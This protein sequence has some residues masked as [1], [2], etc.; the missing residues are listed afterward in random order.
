MNEVQMMS[1]STGVSDLLLH[2]ARNSHRKSPRSNGSRV[3]YTCRLRGGE[4]VVG[5]CGE[6]AR[7]VRAGFAGW[8][9]LGGGGTQVVPSG[10]VFRHVQARTGSCGTARSPR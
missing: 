5:G 10:W 8:E 1:L 9:R 4:G 7:E 2:G 6:R 3:Q